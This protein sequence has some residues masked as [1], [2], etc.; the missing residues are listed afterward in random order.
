[1]SFTGLRIGIS[2]V[3]G[4]ALATAK[5]CAGVS[6]LEALAYPCIPSRLPICTL[7]DARKGEVYAAFFRESDG[8]LE[9]VGNERVDAPEAILRLIRSP[10]LLVGDA[11]E[12]YA[13]RIRSVVNDHAVLAPRDF[14]FP[15]AS[16]VAR[17]AL[18]SLQAA[19]RGGLDPVAPH[20]IRQSDAELRIKRVDPTE[21]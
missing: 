18:D 4:L 3:K 12:I 6:T 20:Y 10:H 16:V 11:V 2:T 7:M 8:R 17:L 13:D 19:G 14:H 21:K 1:G 5:P 9:R 15:K